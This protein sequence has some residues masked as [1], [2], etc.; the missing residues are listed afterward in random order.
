[1]DYWDRATDKLD[2]YPPSSTQLAVTW[3]SRTFPLRPQ[4]FVL[5][6][7]HAFPTSSSTNIYSKC[8]RI[9]TP[10]VPIWLVFACAC[11]HGAWQKI[12]VYFSLCQ[13]ALMKNP[14]L[15]VVINLVNISC[16]IG[17]KPAVINP[18]AYGTVGYS[19]VGDYR[20]SRLLWLLCAVRLL[21]LTVPYWLTCAD[22]N[23]P[24]MHMTEAK[25]LWSTKFS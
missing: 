12:P 7:Q 23:L 14:N 25:S 21:L 11:L 24:D 8:G 16:K 5:G 22:W 19:R 15:G 4:V 3:Y 18:P 17:V 13:C 10:A 9:D 1:M 2:I 6:N 20:P